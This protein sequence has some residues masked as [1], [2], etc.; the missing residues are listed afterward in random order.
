MLKVAYE[1]RKSLLMVW[2]ALIDTDLDDVKNVIDFLKVLQNKYLE[3]IIQLFVQFYQKFV[4]YEWLKIYSNLDTQAHELP[5]LRTIKDSIKIEA[6]KLCVLY[7][8]DRINVVVR[9]ED[10]KT[11]RCRYEDNIDDMLENYLG[12]NPSENNYFHEYLNQE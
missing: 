7:N 4:H 6:R 3:F 11:S 9:I 8:Y 5:S 2:N 1:Y 10:P 12:L